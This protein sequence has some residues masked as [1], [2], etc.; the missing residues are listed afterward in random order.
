MSGPAKS[1]KV[2]VQLDRGEIEALMRRGDA[3]GWL[4]GTAEGKLH[5]ALASEV[6]EDGRSTAA[7]LRKQANELRV[8]DDYGSAEAL[9]AEADKLEAAAPTQHPV[10]GER[11]EPDPKHHPSCVCP[12]CKDGLEGDWQAV[13]MKR[14]APGGDLQISDGSLTPSPMESRRYIPAEQESD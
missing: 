6:A 14:H 2:T 13:T 4:L 8:I 9:D 12:D 3:D 1:E 7:S 11:P 5:N 10:D